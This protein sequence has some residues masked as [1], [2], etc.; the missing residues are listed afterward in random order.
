MLACL[1][2]AVA[3]VH[4][5]AFIAPFSAPKDAVFLFASAVIAALVLLAFPVRI[6]ERG[7]WIAAAVFVVI[8]VAAGLTSSRPRLSLDAVA[9]TV[10]GVL[11]FFGSVRLLEGKDRSAQFRNVQIAI[12]ASAVV[13]AVI[14]LAQFQGLSTFGV[15]AGA[16]SRMR[17]SSTLGNPDFVAAF[18]AVAL[19]AAIA[20]ALRPRR[21]RVPSIVAGLL[22]AIA[23]LLTGSRGGVIAMATGIAVIGFA[24]MRSRRWIKAAI[25]AA[26]LLAC[27]VALGTSLNARA[28]MEALRGRIFIWQVTLSDHAVLRPLG[29][30][31]GTFAYDYPLSLGRFFSEPA[32]QPLLRFA[33]RESHAQNDFVEALH[34]TGWLGMLSLLAVLAAWFLVALCSLGNSDAQTRPAIA[35][36]IASVAAF[37]TAALFDFPM[38]R[39]DTFALLC[40]S[41]AVP[42]ASIEGRSKPVPRSAWWSYAGAVLLLLL[43]SYFALG[44]LA[45]SCE[46]AK[47]ELA[48]KDG[49]FEQAL[50]LYRSA[51]QWQP[52]S[53]DANFNLARALAKTGD[54]EGAL[55]QSAAAEY[56]VNEPELYLLRGRILE[57]QG[58]DDEALRKLHRGLLKF[59]YSKE[60][61]DEI[62]A[63]ELSHE[64]IPAQI[65]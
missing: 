33:S 1:P 8:M 53:P 21:L 58:R 56:Y 4:S 39:A 64:P 41:M 49:R 16:A 7:F 32:H 27:A 52:S 46:L 3:L 29:G 31:P 12:T 25:V 44:P 54:F 2:L 5:S 62:A 65:N 11:L 47:G 28:P 34:D 43:G 60:L 55:A 50:V 37:C 18:L 42:F 9:W 36:A 19:P 48:E 13:V 17:M 20:L 45:A 10:S 35:A 6:G 61:R 63:S 59:P 30:G 22:I 24:A 14:A 23:T 15:D 40:I 26:S 57:N 51:L 38:H